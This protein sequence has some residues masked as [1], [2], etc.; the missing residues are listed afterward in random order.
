MRNTTFKQLDS[1]FTSKLYGYKNVDD[2]YDRASS[3]HNVPNIRTPSL[4]INAIDDP[5]I[6]SDLID[7]EAFKR[8][9]NVAMATTKYGGHLGY[10][11]NVMSQRVWVLEPVLKYF[12][13]LASEK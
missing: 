2:F 9:E 5:V 8:N 6:G 12:N 7:Y 3:I 4:F 11:E 1:V 13:A 10:S